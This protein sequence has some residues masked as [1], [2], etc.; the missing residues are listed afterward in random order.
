MLVCKNNNCIEFKNNTCKRAVAYKFIID[1]GW[2]EVKAEK[3]IHSRY[4][5]TA[6]EFYLGAKNEE[7]N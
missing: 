3:L 7:D 4:T 6:C 2:K 5:E 1:S